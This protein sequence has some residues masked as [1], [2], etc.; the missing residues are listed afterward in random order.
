MKFLK[1]SIDPGVKI[2]VPG[3][4]TTAQQVQND[5]YDSDRE[6]TMGS[7]AAI[8]E[9]IGDLFAAGADVVQMDEPYMQSHSEEARECGLEALNRA[10]DGIEGETCVHICLGYAAQIHERP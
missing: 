9:E 8:N 1:A 3:P 2:A 5:Y 6:A 10:L 7:V 4:F